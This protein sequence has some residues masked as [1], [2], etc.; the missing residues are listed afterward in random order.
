LGGFVAQ[1]ALVPV[2]ARTHGRRGA[3]VAACVIAPM[4]AKRLT[5]NRPPIEP[6]RR[7]YVHRLLFDRDPGDSES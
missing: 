5:G 1:C 7:V 3:L 2:L 6:S 4:W